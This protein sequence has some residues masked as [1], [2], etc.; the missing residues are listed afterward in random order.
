MAR[1]QSKINDQQ[2]V[3][4]QSA[5]VKRQSKRS[6]TPNSEQRTPNSSIAHRKSPI[7]HRPSTLRRRPI[8][9]SQR[10]ACRRNGRKG[11]LVWLRMLQGG[12]VLPAETLQRIWEGLVKAALWHLTDCS[13]RY[14][15]RFR[16]G[17][18]A[19]SLVRSLAAAG[20]TLADYARHL[21]HV[22]WAFTGSDE[23]VDRNSSIVAS[24]TESLHVQQATDNDPRS[25]NNDPRS[26]SIDPRSPNNDLRSPNIVSILAMALAQVSWRRLRASRAHA[27]WERRTVARLFRQVAEERDAGDRVSPQRLTCLAEDLH[28]V[29]FA[30]AL[31]FEVRLRRL[32]HRFEALAARLLQELGL[33]PIPVHTRPSPAVAAATADSLAEALGNPLERPRK[34]RALSKPRSPRVKPAEQ[35]D[36]RQGVR[37]PRRP[38]A[39][40]RRYLRS[41]SVGL[42]SLGPEPNSSEFGVRR[43]E[44][45]GSEV[46]A[47]ESERSANPELRTSNP[48]ISD[49]QS[50]GDLIVR[51]LGPNPS[52]KPGETDSTPAG[53]ADALWTRLETV[54]LQA[55][56]ERGTFGRLLDD[57]VA[58]LAAA[59]VGCGEPGLETGVGRRVSGA[60]RNPIPD[61]GCEMPGPDSRNRQAPI[62]NRQLPAPDTRHPVSALAVTRIPAP[63]LTALATALVLLLRDDDA[64]ERTQ[65]ERRIDA[66]ILRFRTEIWIYLMLVTRGVGRGEIVRLHPH[67]PSDCGLVCRFLKLGH[68]RDP[69]R[70][71]LAEFFLD[72]ADR[73]ATEWKRWEPVIESGDSQWVS[74]SVCQRVSESVGQYVSSS[75][76]DWQTSD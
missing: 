65:A 10:E 43:S 64:D 37:N 20:E 53:L 46:A 32:N 62:D 70:R 23:T 27:R 4:P 17:I 67:V 18:Y 8:S 26:P 76:S 2:S 60:G 59:G 22:V 24:H 29:L 12:F 33:P 35:W 68:A 51:A 25:T 5:V 47:S 41:Q 21:H 39:A 45:P 44:L 61:S 11:A 71:A 40:D 56:A 55:E 63:E 19:I 13:A 75:V 34:V 36:H 1:Q 52:L 49:R 57:Y 73:V 54:R 7:A 3:P 69:G 48:E 38:S 74:N 31:N 15:S 42:R 14:A 6:R 30:A 66:E 9:D 28:Q 72:Q 50:F 58:S 16:E